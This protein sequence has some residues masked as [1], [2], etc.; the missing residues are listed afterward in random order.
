MADEITLTYK[1]SL[2][3][4]DLKRSKS[5]SSKKS[6]QATKGLAAGAQTIGTTHEA[7]ALGDLT[8]PR[9][10][11]ITNLDTSNYVELGV[12]VSGAFHAF[13]RLDPGE[14]LPLKLAATAPYAKANTA[15]VILEYELWEL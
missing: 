2:S 3:N 6:D 11:H 13:M 10:G 8:T 1:L 5:I 7:L 9:F 14:S 12:D 4:G 15:S